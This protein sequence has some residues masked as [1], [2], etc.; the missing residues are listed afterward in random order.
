MLGITINFD[1]STR[2]I[3]QKSIIICHDIK[4][5]IKRKKKKYKTIERLSQT[6]G[7]KI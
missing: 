1:I 2:L 6:L 5:T 4:Y 7:K 3:L